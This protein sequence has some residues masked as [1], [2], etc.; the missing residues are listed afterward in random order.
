MLV[1][2]KAVALG[3]KALVFVS[4]LVLDQVDDVGKEGG[5]EGGGT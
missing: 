3:K 4:E 5:P 1:T 2:N